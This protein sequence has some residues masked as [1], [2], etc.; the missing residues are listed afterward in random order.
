MIDTAVILAAGIG[1][2]FGK[3]TELMPKGF[4][5]VGGISMISRS[6]ET[7]ISC[8]IK[9]IIIG[10]GYKKEM[11][12]LLS[13]KYP[14]LEFIY[15]V[16]F[17]T[18]NSMWTLY[19]CREQIGNADFLLLESDLIYEK[20]AIIDLLAN[21]FNSVM[22][23]SDVIKFQ[24]SYFIEYNDK[25]LLTKCSV[26]KSELNVC[27]ELVGIHKLN[28]A[29]YQY[30]CNYFSAIK[31]SQPKLGYEFVLLKIAQT[32]SLMYVLKV[33]KLKWYEIDD[34]KD[35]EFAEKYIIPLL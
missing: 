19:L 8:G 10:T 13:Q 6:I 2:R 29:F 16:S 32:K 23:C 33:D 26:T 21:Q 11:Y 30:M 14:Q 31:E 35:L 3:R 9:R 18:T 17:E 1:S 15:N 20:R 4:I 22:L 28:N 25:N 27:G 5:E 12:E 7:L 34:D 24:D